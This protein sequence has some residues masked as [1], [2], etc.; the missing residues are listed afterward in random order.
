MGGETRIKVAAGMLALVLAVLDSAQ[1]HAA[2]PSEVRYQC[3][4]RQGMVVSRSPEHASVRFLDRTYELERRASSLGERY[5][6]PTAALI[7][8]GV[9][10]VF[11]AEDR[12]Q[13]GT[14]REAFEV[15]Q[16]R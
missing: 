5:G 2:T 4:Q 11:V 14:C 12:L 16:L 15:A 3:D 8:D 1:A 10:A 6:S 7:I 9:S 13:L